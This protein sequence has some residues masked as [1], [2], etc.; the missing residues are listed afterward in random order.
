VAIEAQASL[1][2]SARR[3]E[4]AAP[5]TARGMPMRPPACSPGSSAR[6]AAC[7]RSAAAWSCPRCRRAAP[8]CA[9]LAAPRRGRCTTARWRAATRGAGAPRQGSGA[10]RCAAAAPEQAA[11]PRRRA[12]GTS[13]PKALLAGHPLPL[14]HPAS[15]L[16]NPRPST[17]PP[18]SSPPTHRTFDCQV[19]GRCVP[20]QGQPGPR[21]ADAGQEDGGGGAGRVAAG[22]VG[23]AAAQAR[24][25]AWAGRAVGSSR[26]ARPGTACA[27]VHSVLP[28]R[29]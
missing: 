20:V 13:P 25:G 29:A 22:G 27:C 16:P 3:A 1:T 9:R 19:P 15:L 10:R 14:N 7:P 21:R 5:T 6:L 28:G 11:A 12:S 4:L 23:H 2:V 24:C 18:A 8:G 17:S 26:L